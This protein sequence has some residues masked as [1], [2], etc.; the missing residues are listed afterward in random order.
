METYSG[1]NAVGVEDDKP[2]TDT[3]ALEAKVIDWTLWLFAPADC[4][5]VVDTEA[6]LL[7]LVDLVTTGARPVMVTVADAPAARVPSDAVAVG[8]A[9]EQDPVEIW[10][11]GD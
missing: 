3:P 5:D 2:V 6:V 10:H 11:D 9:I 7:E 1:V 8:L 4:A